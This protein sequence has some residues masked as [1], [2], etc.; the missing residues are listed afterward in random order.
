MTT[1]RTADQPAPPLPPVTVY[2]LEHASRLLERMARE[3]T[4]VFADAANAYANEHRARSSRPLTPV[5]AAQVAAG[6]AGVFEGRDGLD[7]AETVQT[8]KLRAVDE[9]N[10]I[11]VLLAAGVAT[12]PEFLDIVLRLVALVE[13]SDHDVEEAAESGTLD[14]ELN[15][16]SKPLR[17]LELAAARARA[18]AALGHVAEAA[19]EPSG[20]AW[21]LIVRTIS[22]A[23]RD[24]IRP[25]SISSSL[26]GSLEPT[27]GLDER[28][29]TG[30]GG[31]TP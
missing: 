29:S 13:M 31:V 10:R 30:P 3:K 11:E 6:L 23:L 19:G 18:A 22:A 14:D 21:G 7:L 12:A 25:L 17:H 16:R 15:Q 8:S 5:E 2:K 4:A 1:R 9:P 28:S 27:D 24:A 20:E 26:T